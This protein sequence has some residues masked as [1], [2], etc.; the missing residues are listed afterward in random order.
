MCFV[1]VQGERWL[2]DNEK[3]RACTRCTLHGE[4]GCSILFIMLY[5]YCRFTSGYVLPSV[6][7]LVHHDLCSG[8]PP[9]VVQAVRRVAAA[10]GPGC[11]V[12]AS[13]PQPETLLE[14]SSSLAL[15]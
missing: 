3:Y 10:A 4:T 12:A 8:S 2:R 5:C 15:Q 13:M 7:S 1:K 9:H 11:D 14:K 6:Q